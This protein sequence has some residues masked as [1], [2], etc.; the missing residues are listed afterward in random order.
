MNKKTL[1]KAYNKFKARYN[2]TLEAYSKGRM[3]GNIE[4]FIIA[5]DCQLKSMEALIETLD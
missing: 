4:L 3:D 5:M 2:K 1:K